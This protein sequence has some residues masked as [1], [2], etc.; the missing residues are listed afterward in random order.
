MC[1]EA[2]VGPG[3]G[4]ESLQGG[5]DNATEGPVHGASRVHRNH[6]HDLAFI[7]SIVF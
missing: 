6:T 5:C 7:C 4:L 1:G 2:P 3:G